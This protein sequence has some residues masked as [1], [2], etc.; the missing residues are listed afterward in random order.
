[1]YPTR[2]HNS[3]ACAATVSFQVNAPDSVP[4][5]SPSFLSIIL[6]I[7]LSMFLCLV[8]SVC[9]RYGLQY[10]N[11]RR[12]RLLWGDALPPGTALGPNGELIR[13]PPP[14][15]VGLSPAVVDSFP[16]GLFDAAKEGSGCG[17]RSDEDA[18]CAVCLSE[19]ETGDRV[20]TLPGCKHH[21]HCGC[22]DPWLRQH[23]T[24]P[25]CRESHAM[26]EGPGG[27][28]VAQPP[29]REVEMQPLPGGGEPAAELGAELAEVAVE[30]QPALAAPQPPAARRSAGVPPPRIVTTIDTDD[31]SS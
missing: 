15:P 17:L 25:T 1:V 2:S 30:P 31:V 14:P 5:L 13:L 20:R 27:Q 4:V 19:Y 9:R 16:E 8:L 12:N 28:P 29:E 23:Q 26:Y 6:G 22:I 7:V 21:F 3:G 24:C 11:R 10:L 18:V